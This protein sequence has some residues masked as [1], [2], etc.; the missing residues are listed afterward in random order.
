[1]WY[2]A[3]V[4]FDDFEGVRK[5]LGYTWWS[6]VNPLLVCTDSDDRHMLEADFPQVATITNYVQLCYCYRV[7]IISGRSWIVA[8]ILTLLCFAYTS[9]IFVVSSLVPAD[10]THTYQTLNE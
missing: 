2:A 8:P 3:V 5:V 6:L 10:I 7:Y 9:A 1:M 4:S